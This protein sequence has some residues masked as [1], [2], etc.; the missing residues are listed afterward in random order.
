MMFSAYSAISALIVVSAVGAK[1]A[2]ATP[3]TA[4]FAAGCFWSMERVFDEL[5]GV[6]SVAV[7]DARL[8]ELWGPRH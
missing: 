1:P 7:G 2:A 5:P 6:V 8:P 3:S 4:A